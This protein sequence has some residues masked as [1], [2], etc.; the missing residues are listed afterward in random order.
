MKRKLLA[1]IL[2]SCACL[3]LSA[4]DSA[5]LRY[6]KNIDAGYGNGA[7]YTPYIY[8][9]TT[10]VKPYVGGK[11]TKV[12]IGLAQDATNVYVYINHK[13]KDDDH[14]YK[15]KV[16]NLSKGWNE[17]A[18]AEPLEIKEGE[19]L[20]VGYKASFAAGGGVGY[21]KQRY[22]DADYVYCNADTR[23]DVTYGSL[24]IQAV[25]EG[26]ALP[27]NELAIGPMSLQYAEYG[28]ETTAFSTFVRNLGCK[29]VTSFTVNYV[30]DGGEPQTASFDCNIATDDEY[31]FSIDVP[32][33]E[34][35][36][37][38]VLFS[39]NQVNGEPDAYE[40]NN[41]VETTMIVRDPDFVRTVV[42]E[43]G[44]GLWCS[45][46]PRGF[47]G[48]EMMKK[49][50]GDQFV[51]IS[52]HSGDALTLSAEA[53][54]TY[55][56]ILS[57][58]EG[59]PSC[60]VSRSRKGDPYNNISQFVE[61]ERQINAQMRLE[62]T[63]E[64]SEDKSHVVVKA[65]VVPR[66]DMDLSGYK[67]AFA[68]LEDGITGYWQAN[69]YSGGSEFGGW[70]KKSNPTD[71]VVF[72][73]VARGIYPNSDGTTFCEETLAALQPFT[74]TYNVP[75]LSTI[76]T[77]DPSIHPDMVVNKENVHIAGMIITPKGIIDTAK[78]IVPEEYTGVAAI[79][80]NP[81]FATVVNGKICV[82]ISN[83][84]EYTLNVF[85][86]AGQLVK[87]QKVSQGITNIEMAQNGMYVV[88]LASSKFVR[89]YKLI[90]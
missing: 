3:A 7:V 27:Q 16:G 23:W 79:N 28:A 19:D 89:N 10:F 66:E 45:W 9:P 87:S 24:C 75:V 76:P 53:E 72:D 68:V 22:E 42:C 12:R 84:G 74:F 77:Y 34:I 39:I 35:G 40:F 37:H 36:E 48:L 58:F 86:L 67:I 55:N 18:L 13:P 64:W 56:P 33:T 1:I 20:A 80:D 2:F 43:E 44:T 41:T 5:L 17:I 29:E 21:S 46:C 30:I 49:K 81:A 73:D 8:L 38:K 70:E 52:I 47:V 61:F 6:G 71:D 14:I 83:P 15:Q 32:S 90:L 31:V 82:N 88:R 4:A 63:G 51:A 11:I 69:N 78:N 54:Y 57:L 25:V 26:D 65:T 60:T 50:Y 85:N 59:L 62:M